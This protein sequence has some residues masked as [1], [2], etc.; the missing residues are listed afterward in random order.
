MGTTAQ[1]LQAVLNSKNA[2]KAKFSLPDDMPFSQYAE[3]IQAGGEYYKCESVSTNTWSGYKA[4]TYTDTADNKEYYAFEENLTTDTLSYGEGFTPAV[5]NIYNADAT[6]MVG[7]LFMRKTL[8]SDGL[9]IYAPLTNSLTETTTGQT[10]TV[11][12]SDDI[13]TTKEDRACAYFGSGGGVYVENINLTARRTI[14]CW[15]YKDGWSGID[16]LWGQYMQIN[17][18]SNGQAVYGNSGTI[19][20]WPQGASTQNYNSFPSGEWFFVAYQLDQANNIERIKIN[21]GEWLN[22][23]SVNSYATDREV[24]RLC[25][26]GM[27]GGG[28]DDLYG[29]MAHFLFYNRVLSDDEITEIYEYT[30]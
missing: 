2:I 27:Q 29:Y 13:I 6:V 19:Y 12:G 25:I 26:G 5:G 23:N 18:T 9:L 4:Y 11:R 8:P 30:V 21:N 10:L 28:Y 22:S 3:N 20:F 16:G 15:V 24:T 1:K 14:C 7:K 17:N